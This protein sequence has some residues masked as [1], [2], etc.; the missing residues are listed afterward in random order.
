MRSAILE[1]GGCSRVQSNRDR[2][3]LSSQ[4]G[5]KEDSR[6]AGGLEDLLIADRFDVAWNKSS[7]RRCR[8]ECVRWPLPPPANHR[9][10]FCR[11]SGYSLNLVVL[12]L[13][14]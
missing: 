9:P 4:T 6:A 2:H 12:H 13:Y 10:P 5:R 1:I 7:S 3:V 14:L 8:L 11:L